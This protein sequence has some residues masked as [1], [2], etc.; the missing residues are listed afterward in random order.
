MSIKTPCDY[1]AKWAIERPDIAAI[2]EPNHTISY[3]QLNRTVKRV[4][5][6]LRELGVEPGDLVVT[7]LPPR[8]E[9]MFGL[10]L[11]HE[12]AISCTTSKTSLGA[13]IEDIRFCISLVPIAGVPAEKMLIVGKQWMDEAEALESI[14]KPNPYPS[15]TSIARLSQTSGTTGRPKSAVLEI[16]NYMKRLEGQAERKKGQ[17]GILSLLAY[18]GGWGF[19]QAMSEIVRGMPVLCRRHWGDSVGEVEL[20]RKYKIE[21]LSGSTAQIA[22]FVR[23]LG[24]DKTGLENLK[25][26]TVG[27]SMVYSSM[28]QDIEKALGVQL[29]VSYGSTEC[30]AGASKKFVENPDPFYMGKISSLTTIEIVDESDNPVAV[31]E[32]G[33]IRAKSKHMVK[34]YFKNPEATAE[35]FRG[36]WFYPGDTGYITSDNGLYL[37]GRISERINVGGLK[38]APGVI[39]EWALM[40]PG[41]EDAAAFGLLNNFGIEQICVALV[42]NSLFDKSHFVKNAQESLSLKA[43]RTIFEVQE[44]PRNET[45]KILREKLKALVQ[46]R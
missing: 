10:A 34:E 21:S 22:G 5:A 24:G 31:G 25:N 17:G 32:P 38:V 35:S 18:S 45:G 26:V 12:A 41:V 6:K 27:G 20:A 37:T 1:L 11:F 13:D 29:S 28:A 46:E 4:A 33:I 40:E 39:E 43:P 8:L 16:G 14:N 2:A 23:R 7:A 42:V 36:G 9:I 15:E 44:I 30:G 3:F 19:N